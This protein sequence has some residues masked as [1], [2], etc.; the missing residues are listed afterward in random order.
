MLKIHY[1]SNKVEEQVVSLHNEPFYVQT[2]HCSE[3]AVPV[4]SDLSH[5]RVLPGKSHENLLM[6]LNIIIGA[7]T[8]VA[9][10]VSEKRSLHR[11]FD[12]KNAL[13]LFVDV[14]GKFL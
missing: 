4:S 2:A 11:G 9:I 3:V 6:E 10:L 14:V 7:Y 1:I 8:T 12:I 5:L 13:F